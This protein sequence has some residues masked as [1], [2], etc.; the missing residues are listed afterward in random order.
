MAGIGYNVSLSYC[1]PSLRTWIENYIRDTKPAA[2][3]FFVRDQSEETYVKWLKSRFEAHT[4][5]VYRLWIPNPSNPAE[6]DNQHDWLPSEEWVNRH[7]AFANTGVWCEMLNEPNPL[8]SINW[9]MRTMSLA[10]AA[11]IKTSVGAYAYG[12]PIDHTNYRA[13][14]P[15]LKLINSSKGMGRLS[16]HEYVLGGTVL[17]DVVGANPFDPTSWPRTVPK[18]QRWTLGRYQ[19]WVEDAASRGI[20]FP[21]FFVTEWGWATRPDMAHEHIRNVMQTWPV[22]DRE[23]H[24]D[25]LLKWAWNTLYKPSSKFK[26]AMLFTLNDGGQWDFSNYLHFPRAR[27][28]MRKG[29][30]MDIYPPQSEPNYTPYALGVYTMNGTGVRVRGG[31]AL[32]WHIVDTANSGDRIEVLDATLKLSDGYGWQKV[33]SGSVAGYIALRGSGITW[34]LTPVAAPPDRR[35]VLLECAAELEA[36]AAK[37]RALAQETV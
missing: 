7:R 21:E 2:M 4:A 6:G 36:T 16:L 5:I 34:S 1:S 26:G 13:F 18:S 35:A 31:P 3:L 29:F 28:L 32:S 9:L 8:T 20:P 30:A 10:W 19:W 17:N 24:M 23:G 12:Q 14:D 11:G 15:M 25:L 22:G 27:E 33:L 37:L